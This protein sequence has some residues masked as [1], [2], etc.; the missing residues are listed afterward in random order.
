VTTRA[1]RARA[2]VCGTEPTTI[3]VFVVDDH[4]GVRH[5][6]IELLDA[7]DGIEVVGDCGSAVEATRRILELRPNVAVLDVRLPDGS[8]IAVCREVRAVDP[9]IKVLILTAYHDEI[10]RATAVMAGA[11]AYL[12]KEIRGGAVVAGVRSLGAGR[13]TLDSTGLRILQLAATGLSYR[14][15]AHR[16]GLGEQTVATHAAC[17]LTRL[18]LERRAKLASFGAPFGAPG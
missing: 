13:S 12:V 5:G 8:G 1:P 7:E 18:E 11:S 10:A 15:I 17:L 3:R 9:S 6:L 14:Q 16:M 2:E 4:E